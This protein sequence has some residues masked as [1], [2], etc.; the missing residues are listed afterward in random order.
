MELLYPLGV[1][2]EL[3]E[4]G[5][6]ARLELQLL[7]L[8]SFVTAHDLDK[9]GLHLVLGNWLGIEAVDAMIGQLATVLGKIEMT[10]VEGFEQVAVVVD[11]YAADF[12]QLF[13]V[14]AIGLGGVDSH[15]LIRAPS[16]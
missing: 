7:G 2:I 9:D 12:R 14:G 15:R 10:Q 5:E 1:G 3:S 6:Q 11:I 13:D 4:I 16:W 8:S